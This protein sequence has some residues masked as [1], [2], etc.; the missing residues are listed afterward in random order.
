MLSIMHYDRFAFAVDHDKPTIDYVGEGVH[1]ELGQRTGLSSY[2][3][4]QLVAMYQVTD[5][6]CKGN[7]LAGM[8]C[9]DKPDDSGKDVC[10]IEK[11][12]SKAAAHCCACGGGIE[13]QCYEGQDCPKTDP[14]PELDASDCIED[15]THLFQGGTVSYPCIYTNVCKFNVQFKCGGFECV[16]KVRSKN[17]EV[18]KCNNMFV[19]GICFAKDECQVTKIID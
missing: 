9:I 18:A 17:Y 4:S 3:V 6:D 15:V 5:K 16:H 1:D 8:G 12:N 19:T 13:V 10:D 14:L 7:D 11:C 2:D